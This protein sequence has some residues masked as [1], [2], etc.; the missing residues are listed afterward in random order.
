M[1]LLLYRTNPNVGD[2][3]GTLNGHHRA[4]ITP[5]KKKSKI[6]GKRK[7]PTNLQPTA[8]RHQRHQTKST[9]HGETVT[10]VCLL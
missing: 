1:D 9:A 8:D 10:T 6:E 3:G 4:S 7:T 2:F 5:A